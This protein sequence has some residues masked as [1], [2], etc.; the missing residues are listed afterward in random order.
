MAKRFVTIWFRHLKTDWFSIRQPALRDIPFVLSAPDHGRMV[1]TAVNEWAIAKGI[2]PGMVVADA[3]AIYSSLEVLDDD[4]ALSEKLL[5]AIAEWCIRYT[6][7]V[8][9]DP[10]DGIIMDVTGATHL[11]GGEKKYISDIQLKLKNRG[12]DV[13]V[14]IADSVGD[15]LGHSSLWS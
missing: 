7:V 4:P 1:I 15:C 2:E 9:I 13:R 8:A 10:S 12:Y 3:R 5:K 14:T 6:N 11:W